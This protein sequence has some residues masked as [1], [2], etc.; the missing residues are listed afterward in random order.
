ME[1][2]LSKR[3]ADVAARKQAKD[4]E[5]A[6]K[7]EVAAKEEADK[8]RRK[9]E[10]KRA[11]DQARPL[12]ARA[13]NSVNASIRDQQMEFREAHDDNVAPATARFTLT[14]IREGKPGKNDPSVMVSI[15]AYGKAVVRQVGTPHFSKDFEIASATEDTFAEMMVEALERVYPRD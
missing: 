10:A 15:N 7:A 4:A 13:I 3:L 6:A 5:I 14:L 12:L 1:D 11:W 8:A 2:E 9:V